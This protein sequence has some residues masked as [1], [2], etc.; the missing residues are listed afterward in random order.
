MKRYNILLFLGIAMVMSC[1]DKKAEVA[2]EVKVTISSETLQ[3]TVGDIHTLTA[4]T[5]NQEPVKWVS[6]AADVAS[7]FEGIVEAKSIGMAVISATV[8]GASAQCKVYILGKSNET[9]SLSPSY[10]EIDKGG[11]HQL[12]YHS[13][14]DVPLIW[15]SSA[16]EVAEV[17]T[18]G[19]VTAK[20]GGTAII[21]LSNGTEKVTTR[22]FVPHKWGEYKLVWEENFEGSALNTSNW[23]IEVTSSPPNKELQAYTSR[24]ENVRVEDGKLILEAR[25]ET[26]GTRQYTS[27]RINSRGKQAFKYGR[28]EA[29]ISFPSGGGTW[30]AF[31]M[32][33]AQRKWPSCGEID[34]IEHLGNSP[35]M[36]SFATHTA[37][38][39]GN[40]GRNWS[41]RVYYDG[42]ENNFH[43]YG[44]EWMQEDF[45]GRDKIIFTYDGVDCAT[46]IEDERYIDEDYYWPFNQPHYIILNL[47]IGGNMGGVVADDCFDHPVIM[48]VDWVRVYQREE[49]E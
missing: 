18:T 22:V 48:K 13:V 7:V 27:G 11:S 42:V 9:L 35:R 10:I 1:C 38:R 44:I 28:V 2:S 46:A 33:G 19:M 21:T 30:P 29:S 39:N 24:N 14:Y 8:E 15:T 20:K 16:P 12:T 3:M 6:S 5:S 41:A 17:S 49:I 25:K 31:W 23:N 34:I 36:L 45:Q 26:Y 43:V 40:N 37:D 4:T 32:L 47:A